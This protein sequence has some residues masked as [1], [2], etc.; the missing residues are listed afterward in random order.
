MPD[1]IELAKL[2]A[3]VLIILL[4]VFQLQAQLAAL[5]DVKIYEHRESGELI[6]CSTGSLPDPPWRFVGNGAV[7]HGDTSGC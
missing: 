5:V 3:L 6:Y 7:P 1:R 2:L 4:L